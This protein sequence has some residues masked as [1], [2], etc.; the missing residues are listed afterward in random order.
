LPRSVAKV[1]DE[2]HAKKTEE[3]IFWAKANDVFQIDGLGKTL[4][5][6]NRVQNLSFEIIFY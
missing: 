3:W 6:I 4:E 2:K 1:V 5:E